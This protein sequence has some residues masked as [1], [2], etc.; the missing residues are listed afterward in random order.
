MRKPGISQKG[1][2]PGDA[3]MPAPTP[4]PI[5]DDNHDE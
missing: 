5:E 4:I 1:T 2:T 3:N